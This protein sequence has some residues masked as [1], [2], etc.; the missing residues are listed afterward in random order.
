M[1]T[2]QQYRQYDLEERCQQ[3]A[4]NVRTFLR[5]LPKTY[6]NMEDGRQLVL[7]LVYVHGS[8]ALEA[9]RSALVQEATELMLIFNAM[10]RNATK[11]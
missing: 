1:S 11:K 4:D 7:K 2:T 9:Q 3:F 10:I 6:S 5:M 8:A